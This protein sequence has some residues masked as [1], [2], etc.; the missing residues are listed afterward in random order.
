MVFLIILQI[1]LWLNRFGQSALVGPLLVTIIIR[2]AAP[3]ITNFA[4]IGRSGTA[5]A[6]EMASMRVTGEINILT[7]LGI[8]PEI[9]LVMP[10]VLGMAVSVFCLTIVFIVVSLF[11]GWF[12]GQ[13]LGVTSMT[14]DVFFSQVLAAL[15]GTDFASIVAKTLIPGM[16]TAAVCSEEG[17]EINM[18]LTEIP[19][20]ATRG[21]V[22]SLIFVVLISAVASLIAYL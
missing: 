18:A 3:L 11:S 1:N 22:R 17:L 2:E 8:S 15:S 21:Q 4:V 20:A 10:R 16:T 9:Y 13:A 19:K 14:I 6:A 5:I 7:S 12:M